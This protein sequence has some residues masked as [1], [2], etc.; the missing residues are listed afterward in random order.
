MTPLLEA[1][2]IAKSYGP[3]AALDRTDLSVHGGE[4]TCLLGDN[5]AGKS[6]VIKVIAGVVAPDAG[7]L[8]V[9]GVPV[10]FSSPK[11]ALARGIA[12]VFQDLAIVPV[13]PVYRN[14]CMGSEP[15]RGRWPLRLLDVKSAIET[16]RSELAAIGVDLADVERPIATLSGGQ[17]QCV[18]IARAVHLGAKVLILDEPTSALGVRQASIVLRYVRETKR[19]GIGVVLVTHN[20]R[21]AYAIGDRFTILKQGRVDGAWSKPELSLEELVMRMSAGHENGEFA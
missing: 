20:P 7:E 1:R 3:V 13:L 5:G 8:L 14:F 17:R 9:D 12:T 4:V 15:T 18:A 16:T 19:R 2:G 10:R 21:H 11:D 6:T